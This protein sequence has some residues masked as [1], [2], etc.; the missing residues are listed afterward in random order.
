MVEGKFFKDLDTSSIYSG[1]FKTLPLNFL[2][3]FFSK[4][5]IYIG[6]ILIFSN[7][8]VEKPISDN[9]PSNFGI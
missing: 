6:F 5:G 7:K 2:S 3:V 9:L 1:K 8:V 4:I